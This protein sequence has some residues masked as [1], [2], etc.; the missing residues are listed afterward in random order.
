M[1]PFIDFDPNSY[2]EPKPVANGRYDLTIA[3]AD[4]AQSK[5]GNQMLKIRMDINGH[6]EAPPVF[7]NLSLPYPDCA[8]IIGLNFNRFMA[9]F[10]VRIEKGQLDTDAL[11]VDLVGRSANAE[12]KQGEYNGN[13][14]NKIV[15]PKLSIEPNAGRGSPPKARKTA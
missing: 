6:D 1:P 3:S 7:E 4:G 11:A 15:L 5:A 10:K 8:Q 9:L 2:Q 12:L 13:V 14:T